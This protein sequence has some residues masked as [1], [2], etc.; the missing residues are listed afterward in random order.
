MKI[1]ILST[2]LQISFFILEPASN[3]TFLTKPRKI[4]VCRW[5]KWTHLQNHDLHL[6]Q[7][8]KRPKQLIIIPVINFSNLQI[9]ET[10]S[11][12]IIIIMTPC[13]KLTSVSYSLFTLHVEMKDRLFKDIKASLKGKA[14]CSTSVSDSSGVFTLRRVAFYLL[15]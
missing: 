13:I 5:L 7:T 1:Q 3:H 6:K 15:Y 14:E 9:N 8:V 12:W 11:R 10:M 2:F 4:C